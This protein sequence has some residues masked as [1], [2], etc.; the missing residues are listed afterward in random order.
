MTI[1]QIIS[2]LGLSTLLLTIPNVAFA[3]TVI[4]ATL[5]GSAPSITTTMTKRELRM[6]GNLSKIQQRGDALIAQR[7]TSLNTMI[8]R[9]NDMKRLS[10]DEKT[11]LTTNINNDISGLTT[12][13]VKL[14]AD[15]D[16]TT[17]LADI[18]SIYTTYRVYAEFDPQ[19]A[20]LATTNAM[21]TSIDQ[22]MQLATKLQNRINE[23]SASGNNV[24]SLN[25]LL[26][27]MQNKVAD[28]KTQSTTAQTNIAGLT[29]SSFNT[30]PTGTHTIFLNSRTL[31]STARTDL[32]T[33]LQDAK[34]IV[35]G[36][37]ALKVKTT[38][39]PKPTI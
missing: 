6:E 8:T 30:D 37:K 13:K 22:L 25:T 11:T 27:D 26:T 9:I 16:A 28:A 32:Q 12:L 31:M 10:V 20:L 23:A 18:K 38:I 14:D 33:A 7:L 35:L 17:A 36:L 4:P 5:T 29:P 2:T 34:Q 19:T 3:Q 24:S 21:S 1:K 15:T 39:T